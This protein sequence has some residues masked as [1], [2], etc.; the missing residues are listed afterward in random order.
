MNNWKFVYEKYQQK[1]KGVK[2]GK[3]R[4]GVGHAIHTGADKTLCRLPKKDLKQHEGGWLVYS[5]K[6]R[7]ET[8]LCPDCRAEMKFQLAQEYK[9][10]GWIEDGER[11]EA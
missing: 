2:K 7:P 6:R 9:L 1:K 10:T 4:Y 11:V 5:N 3:T 8:D